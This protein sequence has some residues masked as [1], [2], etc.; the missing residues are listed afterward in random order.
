[1]VLAKEK[2]SNCLYAIKILKKEVIIAKVSGYCKRFVDGYV[3]DVVSGG[4]GSYVD[5]ESGS[6]ED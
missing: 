6:A 2:R 4:G 5:R 3:E 1:V